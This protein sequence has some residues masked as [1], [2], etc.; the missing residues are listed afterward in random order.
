MKRVLFVDDEPLV[1][2]GL[3]ARLHRLSRK[4]DMTF[5]DSAARGLEACE[6]RP[7][8]VVITDM[9]MPG[10]DG[11]E[12][13]RRVSERWPE[14]IRIVLS[15]FAE[16]QQAIR[17]VPYAHQYYNKPCEAAALESLVER[18]VQLHE[19]LKQPTL[20]AIVG[21]VKKLA[22]M[23]KIYGQLRSLLTNDTITVQEVAVLVG[24]DAAIAAKVLQL[25]NS[26]F[27][28][29]SRRITNVEQAV[30]YLGFATIRDLTLAVEV[31]SQWPRQGGHSCLQLDRLQAHVQMV[32]TATGALTAKTPISDDCLLAG[33]LHDIGY[34]VL[35]QE[36]HDELT[37]SVAL[38][39]KERIALH[40]AETQVI[41]TSHAEIGAYLL[42]LWGLPY[43]VVEAVAYHHRPECVPQTALDPLGALVIAQALVPSDDSAVFDAPLVPEAKVG[44]SYLE[45]IHAPFDWAE[46]TRRVSESLD[47]SE[48]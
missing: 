42:G 4:W 38:A 19:L 18:C 40:I 11:A 24:A 15:G 31:F 23:P 47:S 35:E 5:V 37:R 43:S 17:L 36:C 22:A 8:D 48:V 41:G 13:L 26:A 29:M 27:F 34:W 16:S 1:L 2:E 12:L 3:R 32:A 9:R 21:R 25:V 44:P 30:S 39:A 33:L 6:Q 20:R 14:A 7:F 45:S 46:A 10:M 28:R